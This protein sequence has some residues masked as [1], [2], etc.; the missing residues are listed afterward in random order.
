MGFPALF[1]LTSFLQY[2]KLKIIMESYTLNKIIDKN[3]YLETI[4]KLIND[5]GE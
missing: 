3:T 5:R 4:Y 1:T 2:D